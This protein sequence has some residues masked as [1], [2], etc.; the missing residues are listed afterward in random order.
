MDATEAPDLPAE[1]VEGG[2]LPGRSDPIRAAWQPDE[3][4]AGCTPAR[5]LPEG[6]DHPRFT[7]CPTQLQR[8]SSASFDALKTPRPPQLAP[9]DDLRFDEPLTAR[10]RAEGDPEACCYR[11][12]YEFAVPGRPL[13]SGAE[14]LLPQLH[15]RAH[16]QPDR[17]R[18]GD[19]LS[20][21]DWSRSACHEHASSASFMRFSLD[22]LGLGAPRELVDAACVAARQEIRHAQLALSLAR[23]QNG[24]DAEFGRVALPPELALESR[25]RRVMRVAHELLVDAA[26]GEGEAALEAWQRAAVAPLEF[27][28]ALQQLARDE[29]E[30]ALLGWRSLAWLVAQQPELSSQL[31]GW[32][33]EAEDRAADDRRALIREVMQPGLELLL[34]SQPQRAVSGAQIAL[35]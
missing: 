14:L 5:E 31:R 34:R 20:Q 3:P 2:K 16:G 35:G 24:D 27:Q 1:G 6:F 25:P 7:G 30:H 9:E 22:L 11:R 23:L 28:P 10:A 33:A 15:T 21:V 12:V 4:N 13:R 32:L 26:L 18:L 8:M 29:T 19:D 17:E